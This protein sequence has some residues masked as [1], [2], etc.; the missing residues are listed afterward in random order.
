LMFGGTQGVSVINPADLEVNTIG[1]QL[2][3]TSLQFDDEDVVNQ[4][5][6]RL[7]SLYQ[8]EKS[9][10]VTIPAGTKRVHFQIGYLHYSEPQTNQ[11]SYQLAGFEQQWRKATGAFL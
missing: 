6:S 8:I 11:Y 1:G 9:R 5:V 4:G 3:L 10:S 2:A 7:G